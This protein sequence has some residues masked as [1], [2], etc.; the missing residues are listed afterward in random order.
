MRRSEKDPQVGVGLTRPAGPS[1][2]L[3]TESGLTISRTHADLSQSA[4]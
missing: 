4:S 2:R 1:L 3:W